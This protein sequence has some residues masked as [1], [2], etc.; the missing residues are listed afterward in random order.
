[1]SRAM[2]I[3]VCGDRDW[4]DYDLVLRTLQA[5]RPSLIIEGGQGEIIDT[6]FR[7]YIRGADS[8]ARYAAMLVSG[9]SSMRFDAD[10]KRLGKAA[11]PI[12]NQRMID[13]GKPD[14]VVAFHDDLERSKGTKDMLKRAKAAGVPYQHVSHQPTLV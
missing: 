4:T 10:W 11:G 12:R 2:R 5:L 7:F 3:L 14:L 6:P 8:C 9:R 13:E 1:M